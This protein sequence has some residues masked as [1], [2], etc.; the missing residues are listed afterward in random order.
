MS[1][2]LLLIRIADRNAT[3]GEVARVA[4][5]H[6]QAVLSSRGGDHRVPQSDG[7]PAPPNGVEH[8][9]PDDSR[10]GRPVQTGERA[11]QF[12][13]S[14]RQQGAFAAV[15]QGVN[16]PPDFTQ[17]NRIDDDLCTVS[18]KPLDHAWIATRLGGFTDDVDISQIHHWNGEGGRSSPISSHSTGSKKSLTGHARSRSTAVGAPVVAAIRNRYSPLPRRSISQV[19]PVWMASASRNSEGRGTLPSGPMMV[20]IS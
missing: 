15:R 8:L 7:E 5:G 20:F 3:T 4:C 13:E 10:F 16:T 18:L 6:R 17:H 19:W 11:T 1:Q 14:D 2:T 9:A 12:A